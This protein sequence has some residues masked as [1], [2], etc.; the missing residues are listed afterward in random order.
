MSVRHLFRR[1]LLFCQ[2][3]LRPL[4]TAFR[5]IPAS[6]LVNN[7]LLPIP[8]RRT[9][10]DIAHCPRDE[11]IQKISPQIQLVDADGQFK[12]VQALES[13]LGSFD[14]GIYHL[15]CIN[16]VAENPICK[17][18]SKQTMVEASY[19]MDKKKKTVTKDPSK[20]VKIVEISWATAQNDLGHK[21]KKMVEF[22]QRGNRV[23]VVL[24]I[25]KG[26][27]KQP[28]GKMAELVTRIRAEAEPYGREWKA[29]DGAIGMQ[30]IVYFEGHKPK[31]EPKPVEE[32]AGPIKMKAKFAKINEERRLRYE[33]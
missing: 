2:Q 14:R 7:S 11:D 10:V 25:K 19:M 26:M 5:A 9:L 27:A 8:R 21:I 18:I 24:G 13:V 20:I 29:P 12:G 30:Y 32:S 31:E 22:M 16:P 6:P 33:K 15:V 28:L 1:S 3:P 4:P 23:E 17:L